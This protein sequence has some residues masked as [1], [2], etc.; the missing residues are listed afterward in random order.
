M[1]AVLLRV[2]DPRWGAAL[3]VLPHDAYHLPGYVALCARRDRG[4]AVAVLV[5]EGEGKLFVPLL[6]LP[7]P[8][9]QPSDDLV[10]GSMLDG[11]SPYGYPGP[12]VRLGEHDE[13]F[14]GRALDAAIAMLAAQ[15][16]ISLFV[17]MHPML[18]P[19]LAQF[20]A[21]GSLV[22]H[23]QCV[24]IDLTQGEPAHWAEVR[25]NHRR[26]IMRAQR[27]GQVIAFDEGWDHLDVFIEAYRETMRRVAADHTYQF[28]RAYFAELRR[29][30]GDDIHLVLARTQGR[31]MA[32]AIL[33]AVGGIAQYHLGATFDEFLPLY[34]HKLLFHR[35]INWCRDRGCRQLNLGGGVGG[36][37]DS[38]FHFKAGF[39]SGRR[40]FHTWRVVLDAAV[41]QR[42]AQRVPTSEADGFFPAYRRRSDS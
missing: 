21:R 11:V 8:V 13:G 20:A 2:D 32:G 14:I 23:G 31:V 28:E 27:E 12:L 19:P 6:L 4:E 40:D 7:V 37:Q 16:V 25:E 9:P 30:L 15:G 26:G 29:C 24:V 39:S 22:C 42:L 38:V 36:G 5:E 1:E 34:P 18:S 41:Y 33:F 3:A 17:R 35:M 10:A